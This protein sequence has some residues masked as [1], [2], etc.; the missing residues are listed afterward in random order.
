[1]KI[2]FVDLNIQ[3]KNLKKELDEAI[4]SVIKNT[5][6]I[7]GPDV[8]A[9][10]SEFAK[11]IGVKHAISVGNGTDA[12][13]FVLMGFG[14]GKGDEIITVPNTYIATCEG[15]HAVGAKPV[16]V[17][18]DPLTYNIDVSKI[19]EKITKKTRAI[20]PVHLYGQ[21][22]LM[23]DILAIAKKHNLIVL[24]DSCQSHGAKYKGRKVGS[25][26]DAAA[27]SFY[28]GKNLGCYGDGGLITT[29]ND[30]VD[31]KLRLLKDHGQKAK[32][33]HEIVGYNSRLDSIQA[34]I[35][36]VKLK[37]LDKWNQKR[38]MAAKTYTKLLKKLKVET[39]FVHPD[40]EPVFHLYVIQID[41]RDGLCDYLEKNGVSCGIHYP[42]PIHLQKAFKRSKYKPGSLPKAEKAASRI[43][44]LPMF[45]EITEAQIK[46][47]VETIE[48]YPGLHHLLD[49]ELA[50]WEDNNNND[51]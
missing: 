12:I 14:I 34:A 33:Q 7:N 29:N 18:V 28:P 41:N 49:Y 19:K 5:S 37:Y 3:Y 25:L 39:P 32:S 48:K 26:G 11:Y 35:L 47:V 17:D 2:P 42:L 8:G 13:E 21:P 9:F 22:A 43:L 24:E 45:P 30:E 51:D 46:Y 20:I 27:F 4:Y 15:I 10:E 40:T 50:I 23:D 6:F 36:R 38:R 31:Y 44:S 1:M 16:F